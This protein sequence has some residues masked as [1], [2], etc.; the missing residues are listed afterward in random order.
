MRPLLLPLPLI[1]ACGGGSSSD[2]GPGDDGGGGTDAPRIDGTP[3]DAPIGPDAAVATCTPQSGTNLALQLVASGLSSP[4]Y[5][6]APTGDAR[7]FI[8]EQPG[9]IRIVKD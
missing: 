1:A 5:L 9:R 3:A 6:P 7:L 4:T 2:A 8:V